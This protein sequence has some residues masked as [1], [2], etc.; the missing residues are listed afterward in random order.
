MYFNNNNSAESPWNHLPAPT[1]Y[2]H[3]PWQALRKW[4]SVRMVVTSVWSHQCLKEVN[5]SLSGPQTGI[6][7]WSSKQRE[8]SSRLDTDKPTQPASHPGLRYRPESPVSVSAKWLSTQMTGLL[9]E[10]KP[11]FG[12]HIHFIEHS[13]EVYCFFYCWKWKSELPYL[14]SKSWHILT[15]C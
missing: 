10:V 1:L 7:L 6:P 4:S 3:Y 9:T 8:R 5:F 14:Q 15:H 12:S 11:D 13:C 2:P